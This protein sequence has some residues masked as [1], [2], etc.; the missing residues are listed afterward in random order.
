MA[1]SLH[2]GIVSNRVWII[3]NVRYLRHILQVY[4]GLKNHRAMLRDCKTF[5]IFDN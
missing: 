4:I 1:K 3:E 2:E 5:R